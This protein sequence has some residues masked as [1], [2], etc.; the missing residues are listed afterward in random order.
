MAVAGL[1][2]PVRYLRARSLTTR[3]AIVSFCIAAPMLV[4]VLVLLWRP[5]V[6]VLDMAMTEM[7]VRDV[8]TRYTPLVGPF[9]RFGTFP[10]QGSHPGPWSFYLIAVVYRLSGSSAWSMELA[11]VVIN[12]VCLI[13][14]GLVLGRRLGWRGV[15]VGALGGAVMVRGYGMTVLAQPWNPYFPVLIWLLAV[16][17]AWL[18]L[19][20]THALLPIVVG[21]TTIASQSHVAYLV[22]SL[23]IVGVLAVVVAA[24]TLPRPP[25]GVPTPQHAGRSKRPLITALTVGIV[26]WLPPLFEE[27]RRR[28]GNVS[29]LIADFAGTPTDPLV[30]LRGG[31]GLMTHHFN[32]LALAT[33][34]LS[35]DHAFISRASGGVSISAVG[36]GVLAL[37]AVAG[38]WSIRHGASSTKIGFALTALLLVTDW[39]IIARIEGIPWFYL[40]MWMPT[41][42]ALVVVTFAAA[43]RDAFARSASST[44]TSPPE[45]RSGATRLAVL[46]RWRR[47]AVLVAAASTLVLTVLATTDALSHQVPERS[48]GEPIR[49][50]MPT[51]REGLDSDIG[52][53]TG[54][55]GRYIV[56][57]EEA[58]LS[59]SQGLALVN[60]LER[61]GYHVG[62]D[63][64]WRVAA[65]EHRVMRPDQATAAVILASGPWIDEYASR[66]EMVLLGEVD[67]RTSSQR[68]RFERLQAAV[69]TRLREIDRDDLVSDA[70]RRIFA[71]STN[72]DLPSDV[73]TML[74]EMTTLG[75]PVAV[76][77]APIG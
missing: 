69:V 62:V 28:P 74:D 46:T 23:A 6:P 71:L 50:L 9:G 25:D 65:T 33:E 55:D 29:A 18:V 27:F 35:S 77:V 26:M 15:V 47:R 51:I 45:Q 16:L 56:Y 22:P 60:E 76:F 32:L 24:R 72:P 37:W 5:W 4:C 30:G 20:G 14:L 19:D 12:T 49:E 54:V 44:A 36:C 3:S 2:M 39:L 7:R 66:P 70:Y 11:S 75:V 8:G 61:R 58:M 21:T 1:K 40:T 17:T 73:R 63:R 31:F 59:G 34:L 57:W 67:A 41:T 43:T 38:I 52:A 48:Q 53:A 13:A 64:L 42:V 68:V 10:D